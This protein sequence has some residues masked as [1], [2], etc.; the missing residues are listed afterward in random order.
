MIPRE[1]LLEAIGKVKAAQKRKFSQSIDLTISLKDL[2][3]SKPENRISEEVSLPHGVGE[4][5][6]IGVFA[7]GELARKAREAGA[8]L[9]LGR[10]ELGALQVERK[11]AKKLADKCH[12]FLAQA[13]LM[14]LIGKQ[15]GPVLGPRGRMPKPVPPTADPRPLI[16][17]YRRTAFLRAREQPVLHVRVGREDMSDEQIADNVQ[18]VL[19]VL[20]R[21][22][23]RGLHHVGSIV[24]K[25]TMGKPVRVG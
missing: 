25:T 19:G 9:V 10:E 15:L 22:L 16:E 1:K 13:D 17:R 7:E 21:K 8:D 11:R 2:D 14:P 24:L 20:E 3:L 18:A 6:K 5:P 4:P 12:A 23:E